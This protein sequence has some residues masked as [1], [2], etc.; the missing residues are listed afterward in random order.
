MLLLT[1]FFS[2]YSFEKFRFLIPPHPVN[3]L[4]L[5]SFIALLAPKSIKTPNVNG[6]PKSQP[7]RM[8]PRRLHTVLFKGHK[9]RGEEYST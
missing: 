3:P 7:A 8:T 5:S 6:S 1:T 9:T 4:I 2:F